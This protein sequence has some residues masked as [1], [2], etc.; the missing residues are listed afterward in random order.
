MS[1]MMQG[2]VQGA[3]QGSVRWA[4]RI[5]SLGVFLAATFA[6]FWLGLAPGAFFL[7]LLAPDISMLGY[8]SGPRWGARVYNLVHIYVGPLGLLLA[9]YV[10]AL[11]MLTGPALIW[12]A[13]IGLDRSLGYGLKYAQGFKHT[14]LGAL[15]ARA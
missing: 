13:H 4:L 14:H 1:G 7:F 10:F 3:E 5:E 6:Y 12:L 8:V 9:G 2:V 11:P 15:N